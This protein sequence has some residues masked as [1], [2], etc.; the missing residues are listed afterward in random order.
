M[1]SKKEKPP[2]SVTHPELA[3]EAD[4]WDPKLIT[5]GSNRKVMWRC[6]RDHNWFESP[7]KRAGRGFGCPFCSGNRVLVGFN[8]LSTTH[9]ALSRE[10]FGWDPSTLSQG[11]NKRVSWKCSEGHTWMSP[12]ARRAGTQKS[13]CP[14]CSGQKVLTGLNDLQTRFPEIA[15]QAFGWDP[16][17]ISSGSNKKM[18]WKCP[19]GHHW[20]ASIYSRTSMGTGCAVCNNLKISVGYNDLLTTHPRI[21]LQADGWNPQTLVSG[22][23]KR[24]PWICQRGHKWKSSVNH[25][26]ERNQGCPYCSNKLLMKGFNDLATTHPDIAKEALECDPTTIKGSLAKNIWWICQDGHQWLATPLN[27]TKHQSGCP[28][29]T[30]GGFDPNK[31]GYL[32][33]LNHKEWGMLQIGITNFP[34]KRMTTHK[35]LGWDI[36]EIRGPMEGHLTQQWETA[37]LRMLKAKGAD[38]SNSKIAGKFDGYSEAWSQANFEVKSIKELMGL[39]EE[40]EER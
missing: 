5:H 4:G 38:L 37:I 16:S 34:S 8:D 31:D 18:E 11:S 22:T 6:S 30:K 27:R 39:T 33:L 20:V 35:K 12:V 32:Y 25:R 13:A 15:L 36:S 7:N 29:C 2:L 23:A 3:K 28:T 14:Y 40:F 17:S 9:S 19:L 24:M 26:T 21:A 10:A 1:A